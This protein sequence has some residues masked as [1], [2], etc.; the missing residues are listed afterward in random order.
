MKKRIFIAGA[1]GVIGLPLAKMLI[2]DG[3]TVYGTTRSENKKEL[4]ESIG[5][6]PIVVDVYEKEKLGEIL[7]EIKPEIVYHQLTDLPDGLE[8]SKMEDALEKNAK[9]RDI[10]T[11]NLVT[12]SKKAG[13][14]KIIAQSIAFVYEPSDLPH[15]ENSPLLNFE[16]KLYGST[17]KAVASLEQQVLNSTFIGVVLRNALLYGKGTGFEKAVDYLPCVNVDAVVYANFLVLKCEK[18][19]IFNVGDDDKRLNSEKIKKALSW[20]ADFKIA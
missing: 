20:R 11:R 9:L 13:V 6:K 17:S 2:E 19:E 1:S 10:G 12:A 15:D 16:D 8:P 4:L 5:V 7:R 14:K 18:N 3:Y